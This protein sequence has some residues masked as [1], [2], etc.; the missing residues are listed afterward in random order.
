MGY[1]D[2]LNENSVV[3]VGNGINRLSDGSVSWDKILDDLNPSK[4]S[5]HPSGYSLTEYFEIMQTVSPSANTVKQ[6]FLEVIEELKST[7]HHLNL[8]TR[9]FEA[10][11]HILTTNFDHTLQKST[12]QDSKRHSKQIQTLLMSKE[13]KDR[14][15]K[16]GFTR[17]YPWQ[18]YYAFFIDDT[19]QVK[20]WHI[21]GDKKYRDSIKLS[22]SEYAGNI[23]H[24]KHFNP[25]TKNSRFT[26]DYTWINE[27]MNKRLVFF[28]FNLSDAEYFIRHL[29]I[30]RHKYR[31][32]KPKLKDVYLMCQHETTGQ[33]YANLKFFLDSVGISIDDKYETYA[34]IYK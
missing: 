26:R 15:L 3:I 20:L 21:N 17:L 10:K 2:Y 29:L 28:G 33:G 14:N 31:K 1:R 25:N 8:V 4:E 24:F 9:C 16:Y 23:N 34:D 18:R 27:F 13:S 11:T 22:V 19:Q 32:H 6:R 30:V 7:D 5:L 12:K